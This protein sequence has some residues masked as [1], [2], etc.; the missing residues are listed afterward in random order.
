LGRTATTNIKKSAQRN[1]H[2]YMKS[3]KKQNHKNL[4]KISKQNTLSD[5]S[6]LFPLL[7]E[8]APR[9]ALEINDSCTSLL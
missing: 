3:R 4:K 2:I 7:A 5:N 9:K 6:N 1:E 8:A